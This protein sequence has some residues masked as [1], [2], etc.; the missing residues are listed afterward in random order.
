MPLRPDRGRA[1]EQPATVPR[2]DVD[3]SR[4]LVS[5]ALALEDVSVD[6]GLKS[7]FKLR[8]GIEAKVE[9]ALAVSISYAS[10]E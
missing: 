7:V 10:W 8:E 2:K 6:A 1:Q 4:L 3:E 5:L 9:N